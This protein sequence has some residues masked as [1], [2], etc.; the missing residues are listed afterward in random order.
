MTLTVHLHGGKQ[1]F[2]D[3]PGRPVRLGPM[4]VWCHLRYRELVPLASLLPLSSSIS[5]IRPASL[6]AF[7]MLL[8]LGWAVQYLW[9]G[10]H[11]SDIR[12]VGPTATA[13]IVRM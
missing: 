1:T 5:S 3:R 7:R 10:G 12:M 4:Y 6:S 8:L 11:E 2:Q 9:A 13:A